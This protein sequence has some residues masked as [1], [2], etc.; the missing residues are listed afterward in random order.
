MI[1]KILRFHVEQGITSLFKR[2]IFLLEDLKN[3]HQQHFEKLRAVIPEEF[4]ALVDQADYFDDN[5]YAYY[6]KRILDMGNETKRNIAQS[7]DNHD[8][9]VSKSSS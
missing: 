5:R 6:R 4:R 7:F 3:D 8:E 9:L 2:F 1:R